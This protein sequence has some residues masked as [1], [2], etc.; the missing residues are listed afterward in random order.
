[1]GERISCDEYEERLSKLLWF[2]YRF[3]FEPVGGLLG[4]TTD[5]GW[6]CMIRTGQMIL[7]TALLR[8]SG[9]SPSQDKYRSI[10]RLFEDTPAAPFSLQNIAMIGTQYGKQVGQWFG[11]YTISSAL[12]DLSKQHSVLPFSFYIS[13][14][15]TIYKSD[16]ADLFKSETTSG[17]FLLLS[18]KI[19]VQSVNPV[20]FATLKKFM[21]DSHCTGMIGGR[22]GS[23]YYFLAYQG[24]SLLYLDPHTNQ[25]YVPLGSD[26][27]DIS[28]FFCK[29]RNITSLS[30]IDES[31]AI[32]F[33]FSSFEDFEEFSRS[34]DAATENLEKLL[35]FEE[36]R[37]KE[38][39]EVSIGL[40]DGDDFS[41]DDF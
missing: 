5:S 37:E 39:D 29:L 3:D 1:V 12:N 32:G 19:G 41:M 10:I 16:I 7:A 28:S 27:S 26:D 31:I 14:E 35:W 11:P 2:T 23:S 38:A 15:P 36:V 25:E 4:K 21:E 13:H 18:T 20:Y 9:S 34:I 40:G 6:G 17:L 8:H 22:P 24:N 33:Y 30:E